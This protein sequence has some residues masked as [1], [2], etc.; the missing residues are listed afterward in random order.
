MRERII[1]KSNECRCRMAA[2]RVKQSAA[3]EE[4]RI[5]NSDRGKKKTAAHK[6]AMSLGRKRKHAARRVGP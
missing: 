6:Q 2:V 5:E 3:E 4:R 1:N